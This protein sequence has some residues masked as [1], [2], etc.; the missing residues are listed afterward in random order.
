MGCAKH[1]SSCISHPVRFRIDHRDPIFGTL[2][3][4][5]YLLKSFNWPWARC[6]RPNHGSNV[7]LSPTHMI[8]HSCGLFNWDKSIVQCLGGVAL[9]R[10][11]A[12]R[13]SKIGMRKIQGRRVIL[14]TGATPDPRAVDWIMSELCSIPPLGPYWNHQEQ[15][16]A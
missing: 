15:L 13:K 1:P 7:S 16:L 8:E 4:H 12:E 6:A 3:A 2:G 9:H 5:F 10:V 11:P 14:G